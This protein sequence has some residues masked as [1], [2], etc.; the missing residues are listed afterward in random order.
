MPS[1]LNSLLIEGRLQ[2]IAEESKDGAR[3]RFVLLSY[4]KDYDSGVIASSLIC[5]E[6]R[7][8]FVEKVKKLEAGAGM[9]VV[10]RL[11][12]YGLTGAYGVVSEMVVEAEHIELER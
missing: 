9:R 3:I 8:P 5:V 11:K 7:P 1:N 10:G 12:S 6:A 2:E 4:R